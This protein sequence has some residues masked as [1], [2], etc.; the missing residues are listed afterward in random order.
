MKI[1]IDLLWVKPNKSG[2]IESYIRNLLDG[3]LELEDENEYVLIMA[4]DNYHTF[5]KYFKD[6]RF[7]E[8]ICNISA[9]N[10]KKRILWQNLF[11]SKVLKENDIKI[12]FEPVYSKPLINDK[13]IKYITTIHDL[14]ALHYPQY[15]SKIKYYWLKYCWKRTINT[16]VK[17]VAISNFVKEDIINRY[18]IDPKKIKVIYNPIVIEDD[19]CD[20]NK[21]KYK[22]GVEEKKYFY[23]VSQLLPHKNLEVLIEVFKKIKE[24]NLSIPCKLLISGVSGKSQDKIIELIK[25]YKMEE[26]IVLTGYVS[27]SERNALYKYCSAFLFPSVFEGFGMPPIE[28]MILGV[29]VIT[30]KCASIYEVTQGKAIYVEDPYDVNEWI[31][32]IN[33]LDDF[34]IN[35][36]DFSK[37]DKK[38]IARQYIALL[39]DVIINERK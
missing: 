15:F 30:T 26:E 38:N 2:G 13:K 32:C 19:I 12:C 22:F 18:I 21:L 33:K 11:L 20:F 35:E 1:G 28:A 14:Q 24:N 16:S 31:N 10:V 39:H 34:K 29:P 36:I 17:I 7:K 3:F 25:R 9:N 5:K 6:K 8:I 23:T 27:N 4:K 37:Y